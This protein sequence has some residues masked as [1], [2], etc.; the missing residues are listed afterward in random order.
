MEVGPTCHY[1]MGGVRVDPETQA[2]TVPGL[3]AA[4]EVAGGMHGANRLGGNSLSDLLVFGRRAGRYAAEHAAAVATGAGR[5]PGPGRGGRARG[6]GPVR[7]GRRRREPLHRPAGA[8]GLHA[9]AGRD[10]PH[11]GRAGAGRWSGSRPSRSGRPGSGSRGTASTTRAGTWRSTCARCSPCPSAWPGP[12]CERRESR[13]GHTRDDFP[14]PDPE[15]GKVNMVVRARDGEVVGEPGA[16]RRDARRPQGAVRG[17]DP[18]WPDTTSPCGSGAA[19][20]AAASSATTPWPAR[21]ARSCSTSSTA[22]RPPRPAT[23]PCAGTARPA[24]AA[25]AAP[26]STAARG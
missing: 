4:G 3:F 14:K 18:S 20:P 19:T 2:A 24:S 17:E 10:H 25:R 8:A 23:W 22:S 5:R 9:G 6:P 13:G 26:R 16:A 21:T 7:A 11:R 1:V 15:F 12:R